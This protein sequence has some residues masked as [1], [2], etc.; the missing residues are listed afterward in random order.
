MMCRNKKGKKKIAVVITLILV[1]FLLSGC[2]TFFSK[3]LE[4]TGIGSVP[5]A[6]KKGQTQIA[7]E[8]S[9]KGEKHQITL[10][11][12]E[13]L[14]PQLLSAAIVDFNKSNP[15]YE[16][17]IKGYDRQEGQH[18]LEMDLAT[19]RGPDIFDLSMVYVDALV[20]KGMIVDLSPY[21][22]DGQGLEK[23]N[24]VE[25]VL[26][27]NTKEG[28][29]TCVPPR[30]SLDIMVGKK[31]VI[32][33]RSVWSVE[34]FLQCVSE[35]EGLQ[36]ARGSYGLPR[37]D[38][39]NRHSIVRTALYRNLEQFVNCQTGEIN[40]A[41][42]D[43]KGLL[44][45]AK[46][47]EVAPFDYNAGLGGVQSLVEQEKLLLAYNGI[48]SVRDYM[49]AVAIL[50]EEVQFIGYP[51]YDGSSC[52]G[53][54]NVASYG[55][56]ADSRVKDGAWAFLEYLITY[57]V[58]G[59]WIDEYGFYTHKDMLEEQFADGMEKEYMQGPDGEKV[60]K[61]KYIVNGGA[62]VYAAS[63]E[64]IQQLREWIESPVFVY[65]LD[66]NSV[67]QI[68]DEE[69]Y[70]YLEGTTDLDGA[71]ELIENRVKLYLEEQK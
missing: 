32:G 65:G 23:E 37:S 19:G 39:Q 13:T 4:G 10:G 12:I 69:V 52:T 35:N 26:E 5:G 55:I 28:V 29:L 64:D 14:V 16:V 6:E 70:G 21:L 9:T 47:F 71:I 54:R 41:Q 34:E 53:I 50:G 45:L 59:S 57:R 61:E 48:S 22:S 62:K 63:Q 24:L 17:V 27:C 7:A 40:F 31:S 51:T 58:A 1:V 15:Y 38:I 49:T 60:E 8:N 66:S 56:N 67:Y 68:I 30:F 43:F 33:E 2:G 42:E 20:E 36:V 3:E 44:A 25:N 11:C 46:E 18:R